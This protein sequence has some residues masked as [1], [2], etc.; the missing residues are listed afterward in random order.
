MRPVSPPRAQTEGGSANYMRHASGQFY[1]VSAP[2]ARFVARSASV[3]Y[4]C[5]TSLQ[6]RMS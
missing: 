2:V 6:T 5:V 4:K 1:G 3:L